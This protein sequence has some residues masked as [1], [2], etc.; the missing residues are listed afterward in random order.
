MRALQTEEDWTEVLATSSRIEALNVRRSAD[1]EASDLLSR[2]LAENFLDVSDQE[3]LTHLR[4]LAADNS[5][6]SATRLSAA[7]LGMAASDNG[8]D[9]ENLQEFYELSSAIRPDSEQARLAELRCKVIY[10]TA[11]GSFAAAEVAAC[12]LIAGAEATRDEAE[13]CSALKFAHYPPRRTGAF[14]MA[15]LRL[16]RA[17]TIAGRHKRLHAGATISDFL[18]GLHLD[19]GL[20]EIAESISHDVT[21]QLSQFGRVFRQQSAA[22]T[23]AQ[24]LLF[25][26]RADEARVLVAT[27]EVVLGRGKRR[28]Q[29]MSL[30]STLLLATIDRN[31]LAAEQ[32]VTAFDG[33]RDR[34]FRHAG[35]DS[36]AI[37]FA[38]G[39]AFLRGN[40]A[41]LEFVAWYVSDARR[42]RLPVPSLLTETANL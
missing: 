18:A 13:V 38:R 3:L 34:L 22:E 9:A 14:A 19:Y 5:L 10:E 8:F 6:L 42:D 35:G 28:P 11:L 36:L 40:A 33:I 15:R 41:A 7:M 17:I 39:V 1:Q 16:D 12:E 27:P 37:A 32:C 2:L 20:Y 23:R 26:G 4:R 29:F 25:L 30:A 31:R 21:Q 24:A